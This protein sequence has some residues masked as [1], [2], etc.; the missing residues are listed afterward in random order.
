MHTILAIPL[1]IQNHDIYSFKPL[2]RLLK[3]RSIPLHLL[4]IL[5]ILR[6]INPINP[7]QLRRALQNTK[8]H[9]HPFVRGIRP[10]N[11]SDTILEMRRFRVLCGLPLSRDMEYLD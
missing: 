3:Q 7:P 10:Q 6:R 9:L 8:L 5:I 1:H 2:N 11:F 4:P